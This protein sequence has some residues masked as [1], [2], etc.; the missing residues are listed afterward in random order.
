MRVRNDGMSVARCEEGERRKNEEGERRK[1]EEGQ[2]R[3]N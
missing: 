2:R 3:M 1:N